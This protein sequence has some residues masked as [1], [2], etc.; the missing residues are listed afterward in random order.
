MIVV[1]GLGLYA[2]WVDAGRKFAQ[3]NGYS[4]LGAL[5]TINFNLANAL[6]G[7]KLSQPAIEVMGGNITLLFK[8][9]C[10]I[11]VTG[12]Q[13][14]VRINNELVPIGE[15]VL[16]PPNST[17][18]LRNVKRGWI[19]Y[20]ACSCAIDLPLFLCSAGGTKRENI[21]GFHANGEGMKVGDEFLATPRI[22]ASEASINS[23]LKQSNIALPPVLAS[24]ASLEKLKNNSE[25]N[26]L[27]IPV[28]F[29][30]QSDCFSDL[31]KLRFSA[32]THQVSDKA[33]RMGVR[34]IG[35][36]I[37][38]S[39]RTLTSQAVA[40]GA[41]QIAGNGQAIIMR[42]DR[43]T[44]GGYPIIATVSRLGLALLAQCTSGQHIQFSPQSIAKS[45]IDFIKMQQALNTI[46]SKVIAANIKDE[47]ES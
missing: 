21:G 19:N 46:R 13:A 31:Q 29:T 34:L 35:P 7:N 27:P 5:D 44:I 40:L 45:S 12:A 23:L 18:T 41:I 20:I 26:A 28:H 32:F 38:S 25:K 2:H 33:D 16:V 9:T 22:Q 6:C 14:Q 17:L 4:Q 8:N 3:I 42:N 1:K 10:L 15:T 47:N 39:S 36:K 43:Q 24:F 30:Y 37:E 11:C